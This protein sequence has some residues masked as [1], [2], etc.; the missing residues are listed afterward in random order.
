MSCVYY[1]RK[2]GQQSRPHPLHPLPRHQDT[3]TM[4][5]HPQPPWL[6]A[7]RVRPFNQLWTQGG[8]DFCLQFSS[9]VTLPN[10]SSLVSSTPAVKYSQRQN[11]GNVVCT[12]NEGGI[13]TSWHGLRNKLELGYY[14]NELALKHPYQYMFQKVSE[15]AGS[16]CWN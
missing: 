10:L 6:I 8:T 2:R 4:E 5:P 1:N 3:P 9:Q 14:D 7:H 15:K 12:L 16:T 11:S 13:P